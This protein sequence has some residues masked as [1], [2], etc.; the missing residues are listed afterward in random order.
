MD[1]SVLV[2]TYNRAEQLGQALASLIRQEI[3]GSY[4]FEIVVIDNASTDGTKALISEMAQDACV[5]LRYQF[6]TAKGVAHA[7][8]RGIIEASGEWLA[9]FD[10]DQI[11]EPHWLWELVT[12]A[13]NMKAS[14][15]GGCIRLRFP[16]QEDLDKL[17]PICRA[18]LGESIPGKEPRKYPGKSLPGTGNV[19]LER[20]IFAE[21][22]QFDTTLSRGGEDADFFRRVK[23]KGIDMWYAP[24]ALAHHVI[25]PYRLEVGYLIWCSMRDGVN[26][27]YMDQKESGSARFSWHALD[28]LGRHSCLM[29]PAFCWHGQKITGT[30]P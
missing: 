26:Y 18:I 30:K 11:A 27:A 22:G 14:C 7:R 23:R 20:K 2:I 4:S 1:I 15:V 13:K 29:S 10:D 25:P 19:L 28:G 16:T 8:N 12:V 24:E 5:P 3:G 21:V 6:E 17:S 9:F